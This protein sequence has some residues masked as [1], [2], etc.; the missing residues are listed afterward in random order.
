M[1]N[2]PI[3]NKTDYRIIGKPKIN[4]ICA[5]LIKQNYEVVQ[6]LNCSTYF[7]SPLI[8]FSDE[9]W[10]LLYNNEYF[11]KQSKWLLKKRDKE[12][13]SRFDKASEFL[14]SK[15]SIRFLDIGTGEGKSLVEGISRNW[16]VTGIDIVDNRIDSAKID[17]IKFVKA[18]FTEYNFPENHFDFIYLDSV[19]EHVLNPFEYMQKVKS[20]LKPGGILYL[21]VP[22]EDSLFNDV[23][24]IA[25]R[26]LGL[27][28]LSEKIK[29]FDSPY[30]VI[31]FNSKSLNYLFNS[32][33][34][35]VKNIRNFGRKME[36]LA[37]PFRSKGFWVNL[38]FLFPIEIF[39][40]LIKK[41]IYYEAYLRKKEDNI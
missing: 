4:S 11:S 3:C 14:T 8:E 2:C 27:K 40:N 13:K 34:F 6:C 19:L 37:F 33:N 30:H 18:K 16:D 28:N 7:I 12:L 5:S 26:I 29:P 39:G 9:D 38:F 21:G 32:F 41:D 36:F 15:N 31:G 1:N 35:E 22:N 10:S 23:R 20:I 24:K 25:F 17:A